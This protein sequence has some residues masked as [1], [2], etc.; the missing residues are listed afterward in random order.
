MIKIIKKLNVLLDK[1]QKHFMIVLVIMMLIGAVLET[2]GIAV[3][4]PVMTILMDEN[5]ITDNALVSWIYGFLHFTS[6]RAFIITVMLSLIFIFVLKNLYMYIQQKVLFHFV[7]TNQ[8]RTSER[9]M[10][11]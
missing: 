4:V 7:Y 2:A 1:K 11:T 3:I 9:M 10:K 6:H 5:A 8:F